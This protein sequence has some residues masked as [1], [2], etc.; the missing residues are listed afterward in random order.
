MPKLKKEIKKEGKLYFKYPDCLA[1]RY[2]EPDGDYSVIKD[3]GK[4]YIKRGQK[5]SKLNLKDPD[6]QF[7]HLRNTLLFSL[8]GDVQAVAKENDARLKAEES[9][10]RFLFTIEKKHTPK[11]GVCTLRL[12]YDKVSGALLLLKLEEVNG[13]YTSYETQDPVPRQLI[14]DEV[15]ITE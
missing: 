4:F 10:T 1:M 13:N 5:V 12:I 3:G 11:I 8:R 14:P 9:S 7:S 15:W 2:T 6:S